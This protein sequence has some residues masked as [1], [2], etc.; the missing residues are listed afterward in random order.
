MLL[1]LVLLQTAFVLALRPITPFWMSF[2]HGPLLMALIGTAAQALWSRHRVARAAL[3]LSTLSMGAGLLLLLWRLAVPLPVTFAPVFAPTGPGFLSISERVLDRREV[4]PIRIAPMAWE[5]L[6][7]TICAPSAIYGHFASLVDVSFALGARRAC[8]QFDQIA[9]GGRPAP[10]SK[11]RIGLS[12]RA[13]EG[14]GVTPPTWAEGLRLFDVD[15][16]L[17]AGPAM[18][19]VPAGRYPRRDL[20]RLATRRFDIEAETG[21]AHVLAI[22]WRGQ[23]YYSPPVNAVHANGRRIDPAY[24]DAALWLYRCADCA[25][26][27]PVRWRIDVD[28]VPELIDILSFDPEVVLY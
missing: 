5:R 18:S 26:G 28:A 16:V 19:I 25:A 15:Q 13:A 20:S 27:Q 6:G 12:A 2:A 10:G 23:G 3:T 8:G 24:E 7:E 4:H 11:A 22:A 9:I 1:L 17:A 14:I 21:P